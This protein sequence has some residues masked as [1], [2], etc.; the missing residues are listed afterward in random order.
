MELIAESRIVPDVRPTESTSPAVTVRNY[1][2]SPSAFA[3][4][5]NSGCVLLNLESGVYYALDGVG[6]AVWELLTDGRSSEEIVSSLLEKYEVTEDRLRA[7]VTELLV[8]LER[9]GLACLEAS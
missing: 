3:A 1:S 9:E 5:L 2:V 6:A 4:D 8:Q 7:D